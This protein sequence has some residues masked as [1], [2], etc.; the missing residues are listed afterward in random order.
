[1]YILKCILISIHTAVFFVKI[2]LKYYCCMRIHL[3]L[4]LY[5]NP[6][7]TRQ[8]VSNDAFQKLQYQIRA[9]YLEK[10]GINCISRKFCAQN[11]VWLFD[12]I[13]IIYS[14]N[15][16]IVVKSTQKWH[17]WI[18]KNRHKNTVALK[19]WRKKAAHPPSTHPPPFIPVQ[20]SVEEIVLWFSYEQKILDTPWISISHLLELDSDL[21]FKIFR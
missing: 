8:F 19:N 10:L 20:S 16:Q 9:G 21:N 2:L 7:I 6:S 3:I 1:M 14:K 11:T 18:E 12:E 17:R 15:M 5:E 4:L 13:H